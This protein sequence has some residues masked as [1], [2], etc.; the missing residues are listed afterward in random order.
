MI[1]LFTALALPEDLRSR[2]AAFRGGIDG[3]RWVAPEDLHITLRFVGEIAE[4]RAESVVE[5]LDDVRVAPFPVTLRDAGRFGSNGRARAISIGVD[6]APE[7]D[8][9]HDRIDRALIGA[10]HPPEGRK[11]FPHVTLARFGVREG[12]ARIGQVLR[13]LEAHD[14]FLALP[15]EAREFVLYESHLGGR[16][17]VYTPVAHFPMT[18]TT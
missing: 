5:A 10:G 2:L 9:L 17:P 16:G 7:I 12:G 13:W 4:D 8:N 18:G 6:R 14:G 11:Y 15:F 3:A 1:R